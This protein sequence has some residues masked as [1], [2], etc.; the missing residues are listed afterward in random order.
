MST[1][2]I[3]RP[4]SVDELRRAWQAVQDGQFRLTRPSH[5]LPEPARVSSQPARGPVWVPETPVVPVLGCHGHAGATTLAVALATAAAP[6][7]VV[8]CAG[9]SMTGLAAAAT[10]ELG[11]SASGWRLGRRDEVWIAR[12]EAAYRDLGTIPVPDPSAPGAPPVRLTVLDVGWD[13]AHVLGSD[14]WVN[15]T[16]TSAAGLVLTATASVPGLRRLERTLTLLAERHVL[17]AVLG[18]PPRRWPRHVRATTGPLTRAVLD[19]DRVVAVPVDRH[20]SSR[21]LDSADL[22]GSLLAAAESLLDRL[23]VSEPRG[24]A[25]DPPPA[26]SESTD[27]DPTEIHCDEGRPR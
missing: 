15:A 16:L 13:L 11:V 10:A 20:L 8:E 9:V 25:A 1:T 5:R 27:C 12:P 26:I 21:G 23:P 17:V 4:V 7:R 2:T 3:T 18:P 14:G 19:A 24:A 22:P 6:A